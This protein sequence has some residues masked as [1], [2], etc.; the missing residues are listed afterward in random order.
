MNKYYKPIY[1]HNI[2]IYIWQYFNHKD[3]FT[4]QG[5]E[6]REYLIVFTQ[7]DNPIYLAIFVTLILTTTIYYF[8]KYVLIPQQIFH[9]KEKAKLEKKNKE[10]LALFAELSPDPLFRL[11][12][13]GFVLSANKAASQLLESKKLKGIYIDDLLGAKINLQEN[14]DGSSLR[15]VYNI[16]ERS[17]SMYSRQISADNII[18]LYMRDITDSLNY[19]SKLKE[20]MTL[21]QDKVEEERQRIAYEL[22]DGVN[23]KL[24]LVKVKLV[25]L[26]LNNNII[27]TDNL[28]PIVEMQEN[29][30]DELKTISYKLKPRVLDQMGLAPALRDL[31]QNAAVPGLKLSLEHRG[32]ETRLPSH[33]ESN[34]YR[35]SQEAINNVIK[36]AK[37][38]ECL[39]HLEICDDRTRLVISD[40]GIGFSL[41][42]VQKSNTRSL[43]LYSIKQRVERMKGKLV[44]ETAPEQG[45]LLFIE[46]L[47]KGLTEEITI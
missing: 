23:Q 41:E 45:T 44:I 32:K 20:L 3:N 35:I 8:V 24:S 4:L 47:N 28:D 1:I 13:K 29:A 46:I 14:L 40:D 11:D 25:Q 22:H 42:K 37:A 2:L 5:N 31:C 17:Y 6:I 27:N 33:I 19:E 18:L 36:H 12:T 16:N 39:L 10:L 30:I 15:E 21:S 7:I 26:K 43:G 38:Q 34:L 9:L